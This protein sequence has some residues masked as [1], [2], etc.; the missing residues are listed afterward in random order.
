MTPAKIKLYDPDVICGHNFLSFDLDV[1][2]HRLIY[3]KLDDWSAFGRIKREKAPRLQSGIAGHAESTWEEKQIVSGRLIVDTWISSKEFLR[4]NKG[5]SLKALALSQFGIEREEMEEQD[6]KKAFLSTTSL[7]RLIKH[8]ESSA[9]LVLRLLYKLEVLPLTKKLTNISGSILSR[10]LLGGRAERIEYLLL[11][12]LY[13]NKLIPPE[14]C[15]KTGK[16]KKGDYEG[17]LVLN[18]IKDL[19]T[20]YV[21]LLD[22]NSLY[23][24]I[25]QQFNICFSTIQSIVTFFASF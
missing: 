7:L 16:A 21:L 23:P 25:I 10:T 18:P 1:L 14:R 4:D 9:D 11:H 19:Y 8:T 12:K 22:F 2:L 5:N 17:G 24:S 6:R 13:E 15:T 20:R 3:H